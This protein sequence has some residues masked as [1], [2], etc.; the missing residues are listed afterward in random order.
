MS[1]AREMDV[2]ADQAP[3]ELIAS[4][5]QALGCRSAAY[6]YNDPIVIME[7]A[8]DVAEA[9]RAHGIKSVAVTAGYITDCARED[10]FRHMD[11]ANDKQKDNTEH[12]KHKNNSGHLQ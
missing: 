2:L 7:Y 10:F 4:A 8:V 5:A 3:P 6:T 11:A 1:K 9:C 12:K